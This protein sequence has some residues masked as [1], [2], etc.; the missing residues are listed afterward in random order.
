MGKDH[1]E[2]KHEKKDK[3]DKKIK[4]DKKDKKQKKAE[5]SD[6]EVEAAPALVQVEEHK[7]EVESAEEFVKGSIRKGADGGVYHPFECDYDDHFE[8]PREAYEHIV[9]FLDYLCT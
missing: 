8:T 1:K 3:K 7:N 2:L 4:K 6:S 9:P 5:S